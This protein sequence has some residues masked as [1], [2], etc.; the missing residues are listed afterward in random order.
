MLQQLQQNRNGQLL[1]TDFPD[2][3]GGTN[4]VDSVFKV[5]S[6]Q[7]AGGYNFD[8]V[9]TGGIR[10]RLGAAKINSVA[11]SQTYSLGFGLLAPSS[12]TSKSVF[13]AAGQKLQLFDTATPA[14]TALSQ[15]TAAASTTPFTSG[16]TT[17]VQ[18]VQF[19]N[20][21]NDI[22]WSAGGGAS[23]PVGAYSTTKYTQNGITAPSC[24][25]TA[26]NNVS[27]A[28][29]WSTGNFGVFYYTLV[30]RKS[31]TQA[32]SNAIYTA[33]VAGQASDPTATT[34]STLTDTVALSWTF[35][36]IDT[37][38]YDKIYIYR[39]AVGGVSGFTT[40]NLI[41]QVASTATSFTDKGNLGNADVLL[42]QTIGR[43]GNTILDN[44]PL[45]S[46]TYNTLAVWG[47]RLCTAS[48]NNL[49]I[50]DV[51][52]SES[53][54]LT[55]YITV[56][57]AGPITALA[58]I[59]QSSP[60]ASAIQ[61]FLVIFKERELWVLTAGSANNYTTWTLMRVDANVGC[62][63]QS[64]VVSAQGYLCWV[65]YRGIWL[66]DGTS[67]PI[68]CSRPLEPLFGT[69]GDIDKT[70]F[71][72]GCG[73]LF[74]RENQITWFLSS[75]TYGTQKFAIKMDIRLTMLQIEQNLTGRTVDAVLIQ[76]VNSMPVY[77]AMSYVPLNGQDE[78]M[79][80][81]DNAGY[82]YY[83]SNAY[84]D[85]GSAYNFR[86]QTPPLS[87][88]DPN[89]K[90]NFVRVIAWVQDVGTWNLSLDYTTDYKVGSNYQTT[91]AVPLT[92]ENQ[93]SAALY[94]IA[95]YDYAYY[96]AYT[97][98]VV[99]VVFNLQAG[100]SNTSQGSSI[101]LQFRN[102]NANEPIT[103]HGFSVLW[104]PMGGMLSA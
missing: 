47:H 103:I 86:Y 50:S 9:L 54:P 61:E 97:P 66:W 98:N 63:N 71:S 77:A 25:M 58:T 74:R 104:S 4:L 65:D 39:S 1:Q 93:Q 38:L 17:D 101:Q 30:L 49:Y 52:K 85:G 73:A 57:S 45:P 37:T 92:T 3:T 51:N 55:N 48:G 67:K 24:T 70:L 33:T 35:T 28:G 80:M 29:S 43:A 96:D 19:S 23:L 13:R 94:D 21:T 36:G 27:G 41:T 10:K 15:D 102:D 53:W 59:T 42:N 69:N 20:G 89:T 81:G 75:K 40:G 91:Q 46:G 12:G 32:L 78:Q 60:Q 90:K 22:L 16:T 99:P 79:V 26:T 8:Y 2:N 88:G 76:D 87:M 6:N 83:A 64:L 68:Y 18:M 5:A 84:S 72:E 82:C 31:S 7:A 62:P 34:T 14:F 56:P 11:D 100:N 95:S 44:S